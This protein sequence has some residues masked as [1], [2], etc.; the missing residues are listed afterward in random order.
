MIATAV[1]CDARG[2]SPLSL[3]LSLS[4][5]VFF[6]LPLLPLFANFLKLCKQVV[7]Y[8]LILFDFSTWLVFFREQ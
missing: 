6:L 1:L 3:L 7:S 2:R 8:L 5:G 4:L